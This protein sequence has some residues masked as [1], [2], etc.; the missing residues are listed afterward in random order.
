MFTQWV[1]GSGSPDSHWQGW[2]TD[3]PVSESVQSLNCH[4]RQPP[5]SDKI[6]G[7][8]QSLVGRQLWD[9]AANTLLPTPLWELE[10]FVHFGR[11]CV[12]HHGCSDLVSL[13][14]VIWAFLG[15]HFISLRQV[16]RG[17]NVRGSQVHQGSCS[18]CGHYS[19][20]LEGE[21]E[22]R[23]FTDERPALVSLEFLG[24]LLTGRSKF[25]P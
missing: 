15:G 20:W 2:L 8:S 6:T 10:N 5:T 23:R 24:E 16:G 21:Y 4:L 1:R 17:A 19:A 11:R 25:P 14:L 13:L 18:C 7:F 3:W 22:G 12:H 9:G